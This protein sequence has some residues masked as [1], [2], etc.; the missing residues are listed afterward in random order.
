MTLVQIPPETIAETGRSPPAAPPPCTPLLS[1]ISQGADCSLLIVWESQG[2]RGRTSQRSHWDSHA[3][4][5][6]ALG[7]TRT[8]G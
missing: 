8:D 4:V 2:P 7:G 1:V 6:T 3:P 5:P